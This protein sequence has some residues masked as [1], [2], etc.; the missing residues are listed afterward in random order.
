MITGIVAFFGLVLFICQ[1]WNQIILWYKLYREFEQLPKNQQGYF[2]YR[3]RQTG[4]VMVLV[5]GGTFK[6]G[7]PD[8]ESGH[9]I[10]EGPVHDVTL[11]PFL[12]AKTEMTQLA[13]RKI[14]GDAPSCYQGD[15]LPVDSVNWHR[16]VEFCQKAELQLPTEAQWEYACRAGSRGPFAGTGNPDEMGWNLSNGKDFN[17]PLGKNHPV[18]QKKSNAFGLYDMHGNVLEWCADK[19]LSNFYNMDD[20]RKPN[21]ICNDLDSDF[22]ISRGGS[23]T[24]PPQYGRSAYRFHLKPLFA[25]FELGFRPALTLR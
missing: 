5:P 8:S 4:I 9:R 12:I 3:H 6:M 22:R 2:E 24:F 1:S 15:D 21:P 14:M 18:G 20:S 17:Q 7:S 23:R 19:Y 25:D 11:S 16:C 13:W 10:D